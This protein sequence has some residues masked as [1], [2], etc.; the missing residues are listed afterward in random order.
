M[1]D[2]LERELLEIG[3]YLYFLENNFIQKLFILNYYFNL[4]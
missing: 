1:A 2:K 3:W 4:K